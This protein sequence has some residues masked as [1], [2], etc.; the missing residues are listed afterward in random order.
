M[1]VFHRL[2][3]VIEADGAVNTERGI[4]EIIHELRS[5]I[6]RAGSIGIHPT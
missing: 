4:V 1:Q 6:L 5:I 2:S 3:S